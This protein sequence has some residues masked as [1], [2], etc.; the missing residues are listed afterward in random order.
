MMWKFLIQIEMENFEGYKKSHRQR[1]DF[2]ILLLSCL[3]SR[4][5]T[6]V[7]TRGKIYEKQTLRIDITLN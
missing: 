7:S 2:S 1:Y 3:L 4:I 6:R 5:Y